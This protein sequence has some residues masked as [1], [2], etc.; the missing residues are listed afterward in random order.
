MVTSSGITHPSLSLYG[1]KPLYTVS[2]VVRKVGSA[3]ASLWNQCFS[4]PFSLAAKKW[5]PS[6][7]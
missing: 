6:K 7:T 2:G 4:P 5:S 1:L 3:I